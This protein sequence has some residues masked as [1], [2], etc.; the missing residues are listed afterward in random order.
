MQTLGTGAEST[1]MGTGNPPDT[2][3]LSNPAPRAVA[4]LVLW[5]RT[6][7]HNFFFFPFHTKLRNQVNRTAAPAH[8]V[9]AIKTRAAA[10]AGESSSVVCN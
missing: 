6:G 10:A 4:G 9:L 1:V 2:G 5:H 7:S 3:V 8:L